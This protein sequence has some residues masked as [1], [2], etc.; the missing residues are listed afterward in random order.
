VEYQGSADQHR[1]R[2]GTV[3]IFSLVFLVM[4]Y[5]NAMLAVSFIVAAIGAQKDL[6][7]Q[8]KSPIRCL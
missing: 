2:P 4:V 8:Q 1:Q 6:R 3:A 7:F 5:V